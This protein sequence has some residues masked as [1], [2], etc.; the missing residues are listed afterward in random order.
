MIVALEALR[1][2]HVVLGDAADPAVHEHELDVVALE[3]AQRLGARLERALDV[4]LEHDVER[5][6][7][8]ALDLLEEVLEARAAGRGDRLVADEARA[9]GAGLGQRARVRQVVAPRASRRRR[10]AARRSRGP[11]P[12]VEGPA[13]LT[14]LPRRRRSALTLPKPAPAT[15]GSPTSSRPFWTMTVATGPRP[16]SRL[17]SST[18]PTARPVG[19]AVSSASS[20]TSEDLLEQ[21][22]DAG[23]LQR[24]DLDADRVAAPL[25]GDEPVLADLLEDA[26]GVG[27]GPVH[28]VDGDD[29]RDLGE[30]SRG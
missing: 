25:L 30:P 13:D 10:R 20:A 6:G 16:T 29:D 8:A 3:L 23:A 15:T 12:G 22:V 17:A 4:G 9:L 28:L 14:V 27:V 26:V 2:L 5:G 18:V 21:L 11:G 7:L 1:E 24:G 19:R